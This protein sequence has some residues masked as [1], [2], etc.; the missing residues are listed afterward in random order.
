MMTF[1]GYFLQL[2]ALIFPVKM[3][4]QLYKSFD[5]YFYITGWERD[6]MDIERFSLPRDGHRCP[7]NVFSILSLYTRF[8]PIISGN[9]HII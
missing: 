4:M 7:R 6:G 3:Q 8:Y 9:F 2:L 1:C 5:L